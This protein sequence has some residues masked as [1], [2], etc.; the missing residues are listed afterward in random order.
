M[1]V[2]DLN[3]KKQKEWDN[4]L[5]E[6]GKLG[7]LLPAP[8][9]QLGEQTGT[10]RLQYQNHFA[11]SD[12]FDQL[13]YCG[14]KN[15][16][17]SIPPLK[18]NGEASG[19]QEVSVELS[20]GQNFKISMKDLDQ[21]IMAVKN[22]YVM[23]DPE[24]DRKQ[25][26]L[27]IREEVIFSEL[28]GVHAKLQHICNEV[29]YHNLSQSSSIGSPD[30]NNAQK[31]NSLSKRFSLREIRDIINTPSSK[32]SKQRQP[33]S[34]QNQEGRRTKYVTLIRNANTK[35]EEKDI[36]A[37]SWKVNG[38]RITHNELLRGVNTEIVAFSSCLD[39]LRAFEKD[40]A[41]QLNKVQ[42]PARNEQQQQ[43]QQQQQLMRMLAKLS[44]ELDD[45][46]SSLATAESTRGDMQSEC[47]KSAKPDE[48]IV[49]VH[50]PT[51]LHWKQDMPFCE[52]EQLWMPKPGAGAIQQQSHSN[53]PTHP[54]T[55][56]PTTEKLIS[57]NLAGGK[58]SVKSEVFKVIADPVWS[59]GVATLTLEG[60]TV[61]TVAPLAEAGKDVAEPREPADEVR[62]DDTVLLLG[63]VAAVGEAMKDGFF[64]GNFLKLTGVSRS[65]TNAAPSRW[66]RG[67]RAT[68]VEKVLI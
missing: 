20:N 32:S 40:L 5:L 14:E 60:G 51:Q 23:T 61:L 42:Y 66:R 22:R 36:V 12:I 3:S 63:H 44:K 26:D 33:F 45:I 59:A 39:N 18:I 65:A 67:G 21:I 62:K 41:T 55:S 38:R 52:Y 30:R 11:S 24:N 57:I 2:E 48:P 43:P 9:T 27:V 4:F 25:S 1:D 54:N 29:N 7:W 28:Y 53:G 8:F 19:S 35:I 64:V 46:E 10:W 49:R 31:G 56:I 34:V 68:K 37:I 13:Q 16:V 6:I 47:D 17:N 58:F 15:T 50:F